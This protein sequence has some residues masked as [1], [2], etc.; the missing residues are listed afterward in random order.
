MTQLL[1]PFGVE[2]YAFLATL[3]TTG[4]QPAASTF[5]VVIED[6]NPLGPSEAQHQVIREVGRGAFSVWGSDVYFSAS[7]NSDCNTN[8][9]NYVVLIADL[10]APQIIDKIGI[11]D[12]LLLRVIN[13][14][15]SNNNGFF[16]NFFGY[17]NVLMQILQRN[18]IQLPKRALEIGTGAHPYAALRF[19]LAGVEHFVANDILPIQ[20]TFPSQFV[21]DVRVLADIVLPGSGERL[22]KIIHP[23][24]EGEQYAF[25]GL[26]ICDRQSFENIDVSGQMDL[27]FST[28]ALEH[29]R[30]PHAIAEKMFAILRSG[31]CALHS[32]DFRDHRDFS[33]P[34]E[35]LKLTA[36]EYQK[37]DTENRL[38]ASDWL[39]IF[40][41]VGFEVLDQDYTTLPPGCEHASGANYIHYRERQPPLFVDELMRAG[42][43]APFNTKEL[44]D[45]S[46]LGLKVLCRKP[47]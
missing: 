33:R 16:V 28:S 45:L 30:R 29:V 23:T 20:R 9:R 5:A 25:K 17:Y 37:F 10:A 15:Y 12:P 36:E 42:F 47:A 27:V 22:D 40:E 7:D 46:I 41:A 2:G 19:L 1:R 34:L 4:R 43:S 21:H 14:N 24:G 39:K 44:R 38:R 18:A 13:R 6:G 35:F 3:P 8:G 11:N 26:E 32:I 31:G